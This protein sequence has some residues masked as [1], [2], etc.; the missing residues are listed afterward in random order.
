M[1]QVG[2]SR[3]RGLEITHV[4]NGWLS[5]QSQVFS[6]PLR[7]HA[8]PQSKHVVTRVR[9]RPEEPRATP[10]QHRGPGENPSV[11][12]GILR[13]GRPRP[14]VVRI[15]SFFRLS[16]YFLAQQKPH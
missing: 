2:K 6:L 3:F 16:I 9:G 7:T 11:E 8:L 1:L 4:V 10:S 12:T 14:Q 13:A 5:A 15:S